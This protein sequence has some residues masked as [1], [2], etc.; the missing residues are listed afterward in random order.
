MR[1]A[2]PRAAYAAEGSF[3]FN[4]RAPCGA[5]RVRAVQREGGR[6]FNP[7]APCGARPSPKSVGVDMYPFQSTR[8][9]RGATAEV[10]GCT[11]EE[12]F[13]STR[14]M[15]GA[16]LVRAPYHVQDG[17]QSTR[18]MRGATVDAYLVLLGL[19]I[20]IHA[21]H[22]GRDLEDCVREPLRNVFQSTRPMRGATAK[23]YKIALHT[24]ATKGN[25]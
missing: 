2:T 22:A 10:Y 19:R 4:P 11:V 24:F 12:K 9:M 25:S 7:R 5:R 13:Q 18:P 15:R 3:Y 1:G 17:F 20:S 21:P 23:V 6:D 14:P 8:P 16:T